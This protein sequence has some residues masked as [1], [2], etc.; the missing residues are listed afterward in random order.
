[1]ALIFRVP[2]ANGFVVAIIVVRIPVISVVVAVIL[3]VSFTVAMSLTVS[4]SKRR[5]T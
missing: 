3:V 1:M 5:A 4:L 2:P